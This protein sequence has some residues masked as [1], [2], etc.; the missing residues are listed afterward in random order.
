MAWER[1]D[2]CIVREQEERWKSSEI[3]TVSLLSFLL[4]LS[5]S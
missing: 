3:E 4:S 1:E 2:R 5:P